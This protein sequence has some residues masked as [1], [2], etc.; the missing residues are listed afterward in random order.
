MASLPRRSVE[1]ARLA[2]DAVDKERQR[3]LALVAEYRQGIQ[4]KHAK[5]ASPSQWHN[6]V[7]R[8]V[9][10]ALLQIEANIRHPS[11]KE[12][13]EQVLPGDFTIDEMERA[14]ALIEDQERNPFEG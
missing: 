10:E 6:A 9:V 4:R 3:C 5:R 8:R 1:A 11:A 13:P 2:V 14:I 12:D 7:V